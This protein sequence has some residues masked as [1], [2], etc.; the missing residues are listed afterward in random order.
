MAFSDDKEI[1]KL[2]LAHRALELVTSVFG[3]PAS[4]NSREWRFLSPGQKKDASPAFAVN[5]TGKQYG[6]YYDFTAGTHGDMLQFISDHIV[7]GGFKEA[8]R[9][10][11]DW[12][13]WNDGKSSI[14][15]RKEAARR[16]DRA[17]AD[18]DR[19]SAEAVD[20]SKRI[21]DAR[22]RWGTCKPI[23][24]TPAELYLASRGIFTDTPPA[25]VRWSETLQALTFA[26]TDAAGEVC[27]LQYVRLT[28]SGEKDESRDLKKFSKGPTGLGSVKFPGDPSKPVCYAEGPET[29]MSV[30]LAT[31]YETHAM[32]GVSGFKSIPSKAD[33]SRR[34]ILCRDDDKVTDQSYK[35]AQA[36]VS[37]LRAGGFDFREAWPFDVRRHS[38]EDF[39]DIKSPVEIRRRIAI[40]NYDAPI[41]PRIETSIDTARKRTDEYVSD[42]IEQAIN[43]D[44]TGK[45][46]VVVIKITVGGGKSHAAIHHAVLLIKRLRDAGDMRPIVYLIPEHKLA[47]E[48]AQRFRNAA[49]EEGVNCTVDVYRGRAARRA[50]ATDPDERMCQKHELVAEAERLAVK[51]DD[52]ICPECPF[53]SSCAY[54]AQKNKSADIWIAS[55]H[56]V[57]NDHVQP[58][59]A[60]TERD[61]LRQ[62]TKSGA[63]AAI[64]D[65]SIVQAGLIGTEGR[66]VVVPLDL[67]ADPSVPVPKI[68]P[69]DKDFNEQSLRLSEHR[70]TLSE[71][72]R[73][74]PEGPVPKSVLR[75]CRL[76]AEI[77]Q[78]MA[79]AE[80]SRI[81][82]DGPWRERKENWTIKLFAALWRAIEESLSTDGDLC[83]WLTICRTEEGAMAV[84]ITGRRK[85]SKSMRTPTLVI[86]AK[87]DEHLLR[88]FWPTA[89]FKQPIRVSA[90]HQCIRQMTTKSF[91]Q[92]YL[93]PPKNGDPDQTKAR[94][95]ALRKLRAVI[96]REITRA[97]GKAAVISN[98]AVIEELRLPKHVPTL[99][100]NA[101]A[102]RDHLRDVDLLIVIGRPSA[103]PVNIE[104]MASALTGAPPEQSL[105]DGWYPK[106]DASRRIKEPTGE[107][108]IPASVD[109]HPDAT[110]EALRALIAS[111]E[112]EQA[113]GRARGV[114]RS[115]D[116]PVDVL[117][118]TDV[119]LDAA[120]DELLTDD[121]LAPSL[122][123]LQMAAGGIA[124]ENGTMM[125]RAYPDLWR[126]PGDARKAREREPKYVTFSYRESPYVNV[127]HFR[128]T[129]Q[130]AQPQTA[131]FIPALV[132]DPRATIEGIVGSLAAFEI[133]CPTAV[134]VPLAVGA[135][136]MPAHAPA[137]ASDYPTQSAAP[138]E[139]AEPAKQPGEIAGAIEPGEP[140]PPAEDTI[141]EELSG[142]GWTV[143]KR[144]DGGLWLMSCPDTLPP[145]QNDD[146][147]LLV[148][149]EPPK[150]KRAKRAKKQAGETTGL[151]L[152]WLGEVLAD[153]GHTRSQFAAL[154][155]MSPSHLRNLESGHRPATP[156]QMEAIR[157]AAAGLHRT[158]ARLL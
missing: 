106:A 127:T 138:G 11:K 91:A 22:W 100:F 102:G 9:W 124:F 156:E 81:I 53:K 135:E 141:I 154:V 139:P 43:W 121:W 99:W 62:I 23:T 7:A 13:R 95:K 63:A 64:V 109:R 17:K 117:V 79:K 27:G 14:P 146:A 97:R 125:S 2:E 157:Q 24:G 123:D 85:V 73:T 94:A 98:K 71:A 129:G 105:G 82:K 144:A 92:T 149:T 45:P 32:L 147:A 51:A 111:G 39:N 31:G 112:V 84:R 155:G 42:F 12:L 87:A 65:E 77:A 33:K 59:G 88:Y 107:T 25:C 57:F 52:E 89:D 113:I 130:G 34:V 136:D 132:Y 137:P 19:R 6:T 26:A 29:A 115:Q 15:M 78:Q 10:A 55:H 143:V 114:G 38:K 46:P 145:A 1:I 8:L 151:D 36:A 5:R 140:S 76:D 56:F 80:W 67:L 75:T 131:A 142:D 44:N 60:L 68:K 35:A 104:R 16:L 70:I 47:D 133:T 152:S 58:I 126:T 134:P 69:G 18:A 116:A 30:W 93:T 28:K 21:S 83:G 101:T 74:L 3:K 40:A 150:A 49:I 103:K 72:L 4:T 110:C 122:D 96:I 120:V 119:L 148:A 90:P 66:G 61:E 153:T 86:D 158:Q 20:E 50:D 108:E 54:L 118:L 37:E 128:Q 41:I 48:I